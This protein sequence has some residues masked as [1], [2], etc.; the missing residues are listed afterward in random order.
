MAPLTSLFSVLSRTRDSLS[1]ALNSLRAPYEKLGSLDELEAS[2]LSSD[3]GMETAEAVLEIAKRSKSGH[4]IDEIIDLLIGILESVDSGPITHIDAGPKVIL[5]VGVNGTGKTTSAAKLAGLMKTDEPALLIGADTYR[6]AA[7]EQL[8]IWAQRV[9]V[10]LVS[11]EASK[12]PSAVLFDGMSSAI[13]QKVNNV[14]VDTAGRLHTYDHLME[15]LSK[16]NRVL[17]EHFPQ[18]NTKSLITI[19]ASLGQ[20]SLFQAKSFAKHV[21]LDGAI[22]TKMDGTAKG[23]IVFA[24]VKELSLPVRYI[25]IG[26]DIQDIEPFDAEKFVHSLVGSAN[27]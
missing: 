7:V 8:R 2:L 20:N 22:L 19:D 24:L 10:R 26:E 11:N 1:K 4:A 5:I 23:G 16:M 25:G 13:A 21:D 6:A 9:D 18:F 17:K 27:D 12:D 14:I 3:I 15:E